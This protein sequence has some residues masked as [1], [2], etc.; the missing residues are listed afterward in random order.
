MNDRNT[1]V[2]RNKKNDCNDENESD[3]NNVNESG[4]NNSDGNNEKVNNDSEG[5]NEEKSKSYWKLLKDLINK[6]NEKFIEENEKDD[7]EI[8]FEQVVMRVIK[9]EKE[10]MKYWYIIGKTIKT[11]LGKKQIEEK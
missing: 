11:D 5:K 3:G 6:E 8:T 9:N 2:K 7:D 10:S 1:G 4:N